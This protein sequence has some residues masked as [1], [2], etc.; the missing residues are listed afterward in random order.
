MGIIV[1]V[2]ML[3]GVNALSKDN[4]LTM[5]EVRLAIVVS[6]ITVFFGLLAVG[7]EHIQ[8][9]IMDDFSTIIIAICAFFFGVRVLDVWSRDKTPKTK[10]ET[11]G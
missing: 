8:Y 2:T 7:D 5:E 6:F 10:S 4:E 11:E 1:F 9:A 3:L